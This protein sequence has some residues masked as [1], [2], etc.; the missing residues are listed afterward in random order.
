[1]T[2]TTPTP[3]CVGRQPP[4]PAPA[5][6]VLTAA[7]TGERAR[8]ARTESM[9]LRPQRDGRTIVETDGGTY[10][11]DADHETCTCPDFAIRGARCKHR[12]RV[13]IEAAVGR[14]PPAGMR[15]GVCAVCGEP[16]PVPIEQST[17]L[18]ETHSFEPGEFVVDRETGSLLVVVAV[19]AER[20]DSRRTDDGRLIADVET[21]RAY[22]DHEPVV[23]GVY[24]STLGRPAKRYG[25]PASRLRHT[26]R[27]PTDTRRLS[28]GSAPTSEATV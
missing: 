17:A 27:D 19:T 21:N 9:T 23:E 4:P 7:G 22:G 26:A 11:V 15:A 25:F 18:C 3:D 14:I 20:A 16:Q 28:V 24:V 12:R 1:M 5:N 13:A 10:V 8:R 6:L 2:A